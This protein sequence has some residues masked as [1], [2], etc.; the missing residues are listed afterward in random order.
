MRS[1]PSAL[2]SSR[3]T[4]TKLGVGTYLQP[5]GAL[6]EENLADFR[7]SVAA[8]SVGLVDG[9]ADYFGVFEG[10]RELRPA[11]LQPGDQLGDGGD[12]ARHI[13]VLGGVSDFLF[14]PSEIQETHY[15]SSGT[16][17]WNVARR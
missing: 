15:S 2:A 1:T 10:M 16:T 8:V 7:D 4:T 6:V 9:R 17:W 5:N 12:I 3:F 14:H 11:R 13:D